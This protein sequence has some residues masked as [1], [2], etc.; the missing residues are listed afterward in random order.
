MQKVDSVSST[1]SAILWSIALKSSWERVSKDSP[2]FVLPFV[3]EA[4]GNFVS[5]LI[6]TIKKSKPCQPQLLKEHAI[7]E[8]A[9][10][11]TYLYYIK[12]F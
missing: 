6:S 9:K 8:I 11:I 2:V 3:N 1:E 12:Q 5:Q 7:L 4:N 10:L